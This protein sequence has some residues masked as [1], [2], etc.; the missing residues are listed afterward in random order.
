MD[1]APAMDARHRAVVEELVARNRD[2]PTRIA[3]ILCGS[4]A[5]GTARENSDVDLYVVVTDEELERVAREK[6]FF[7]GSWD[8]DAFSGLGVDGKI[9]GMRYL[10]EAVAR[11]NEPTR[12][13]FVGAR[14]VFSR[15][16]EIAELIRRIGIYPEWERDAKLR[17]FYGQ[18]KHARYVG[19]EGT[20]LGDAYLARRCFMD[21][22]FF[23]AR[24]V[25]AHNRVLFPC[26][27]RLFDVLAR[28]REMPSG[29]LE[30]TRAL[31]ANLDLDTARPYFEDVI[32]FFRAYDH[33]DAE[34]VGLVLE[35]ESRWFWGT[36]APADW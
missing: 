20:Q 35:D 19:E 27:K 7:Y 5:N 15:S 33:P 8:P 13:S 3:L 14:P 11:A 1:E 24:L 26:H 36:P 29:F 31:V 17:V 10:R 23:A 18:V 9:V 2:D 30:R 22:A 16:A 4:V 21:L 6:R 28:C 32:A 12:A 25:L 34:R